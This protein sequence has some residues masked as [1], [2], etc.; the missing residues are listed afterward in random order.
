MRQWYAELYQLGV[1]AKRL[2]V[3]CIWCL[4]RWQWWKSRT[5]RYYN[6]NRTKWGVWRTSLKISDCRNWGCSVCRR[7]GWGETLSLYSYLKGGCSEA[8]VG[9]FSQVT[10]N[11]TR[12]NGL[13]LRQGRFSLEIVTNVMAERVQK[14]CRCVRDDISGWI[15][16]SL[17]LCLSKAVEIL[18][19]WILF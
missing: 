17:S 9:L 16:L 18:G 14:P 2:L 19:L 7:G 15:S 5:L 6:T 13:K 4:Y 10:S 3:T 12:G 1:W 11:R 8:D